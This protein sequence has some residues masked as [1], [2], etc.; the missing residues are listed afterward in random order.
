MIYVC[1]CMC[2]RV[3]AS[4]FENLTIRRRCALLP[5]NSTDS[6]GT[7]TVYVAL[8]ILYMLT[9]GSTPKEI[10][11]VQT[12][13]FVSFFSRAWQEGCPHSQSQ[14]EQ[15]PLSPGS[16]NFELSPRQGR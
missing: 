1:M 6:C 13:V 2:T 4:S 9:L 16:L 7:S 15:L 3:R 8:L 11:V 10:S 12:P 5:N 14:R